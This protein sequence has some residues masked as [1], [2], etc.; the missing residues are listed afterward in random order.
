MQKGLSNI[1]ILGIIAAIVLIGAGV[2]GY[3]V[4][5][6]KFSTPPVSKN[7]IVYYSDSFY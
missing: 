4:F 3:L 6:K 5:V 7:G 1:L 2:G